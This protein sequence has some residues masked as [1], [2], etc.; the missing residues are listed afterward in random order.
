VAQDETK[1]AV[2]PPRPT[3]PP[4]S[5]AVTLDTSETLFTVL[6]AMNVCGYDAGLEGSN[7]LRAQIRGEVAAAI[8]ASQDAQE[9]VD[10]MCQLYKQH[11]QDDPSRTLAQ[12]VSLALYLSPPPALTT[13]VKDAD[14]APDA[15][16][17]ES[18]L[19]ALQK[20]YEVAG[21]HAI[22]GRHE[23][24]YEALAARYHEPLSKM[25]FETEVYLKLPSASYLGRGFTVYLE[26]MGAPGQTNARTYASDYYVV[27]SAGRDPG[28]KMAQIRHTYLH[29]L[30]D[31][32]SLKYP[33]EMARLTPLLA[34]VKNAPMDEGF[35]TDASLLVTE[36]LIRAIEARTA[37]SSKTPEAQRQQAVQ[38]SMEQGFILTRY[39]YDTLVKFEKAPEG[40]RG[41]FPGMLAGIDVH[42]E[43][44]EVALIH[45][46]PQ[47]DP[48]V[49]HLTPPKQGQVLL[50]AEERLLA[51]DP[52]NAQKLAQQALDDK[53]GDPGRALFV[54][55]QVAT[56]RRDMEGARTYF[57]HALEVAQEPK[58]VAW[59]HIYLG[60]I[61]DLEEERDAAVGEYKAALNAGGA[62]PEVKAAAERGLKQPYEPPHKPQPQE[63]DK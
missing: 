18:I 12:Y 39:F 29:Y 19:P 44:K 14:L 37:G 4:Q 43:E 53:D 60:R 22:W 32:L 16:A 54:L 7:P 58:V 24:T 15:A 62:L 46:A 17:V 5:K 57:Q 33:G 21:L 2:P 25:L 47:A 36:C 35:K 10:N 63:Q 3:P 40:L 38:Q 27:I 50:H 6:T 30:L 31:A 8:K 61:F 49:L 23:A 55:A 34:T 41:A 11:E 28:L 20:F 13:T 45:F 1:P 51:G 9:V 59:S 48:E 56:M 26:V 52:E 42:H